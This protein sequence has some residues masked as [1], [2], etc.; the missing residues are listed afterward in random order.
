MKF[1]IDI[2]SY[3]KNIDLVRAKS[4]GVQFA[5]LRAGFTGYGTGLSKNKDKAFESLYSQCKKLGIPVGAYWYSCATT[6]ANGR[7]EAEFLYNNCLKDKQ[8]EYPIYIDV[9]DTRHQ[10][11]AGKEAVTSAIKGFCEYIESKG[12][13]V[14]I[15]ANSYWFKNYI[16]TS[17]LVR[18]DKWVATWNKSRPTVVSHG[19]WQFGGETNCIRSNRVAGLVCD[20][21]YAYKDYPAIIKKAKLNGFDD[22]KQVITYTVKKGDTLSKIAKTY[23]TTYQK[24]AEDNNIKNVNLIYP[25]QKLV[26]K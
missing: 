2:S 25:G 5:I 20:Q 3:Q 11:K 13:Y 8:F 19:M 9:E 26:I 24:I 14:G 15:Y 12:F 7:A 22:K 18:Y 6:Y 17:A 21:N 4:E 16:N 23:D 1:G 10:Q